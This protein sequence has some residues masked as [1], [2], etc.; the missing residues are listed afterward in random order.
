MTS[1]KFEFRLGKPDH[2]EELDRLYAIIDQL[3]TE[4]I[5]A[6]KERNEA[7]Q[8]LKDYKANLVLGS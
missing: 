8:E 5:Q 1:D 7:V 6:I 2:S 4:K 3:E